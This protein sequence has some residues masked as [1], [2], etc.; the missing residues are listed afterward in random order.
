MLPDLDGAGSD[1]HPLALMA[2][3]TAWVRTVDG[4]SSSPIT[5]LILQHAQ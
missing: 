4:A 5:M 3:R 2:F 1:P